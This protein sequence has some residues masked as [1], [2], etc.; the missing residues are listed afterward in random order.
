MGM[1]FADTETASEADLRSVGV[2]KYAEHPST[3][4]QLFSYTFDNDP[5][6]RLWSQEEGEE[7]PDELMD[8]FMDD[9]CILLFHNSQFDRVIIEKTLGIVLPIT[10]Y[11]CMMAQALSHS[12]PGALDKLGAAF[13]ISEDVRKIRDGHRLVLKFCKPRGKHQKW[14]TPETDPDDWARYKEYC[15][16]DTR[17]MR[18]LYKLLPRW[19]YPQQN[20]LALWILDQNMNDRG[21][22]IDLDLVQGAVRA[23]DKEQ[24]LLA[25]QTK[26]MTNGAVN[27]AS[28]RDAMLA[29]ILEEFGIILPDMRKAT[30]EKM[31]DD[32]EYPEALRDLIQVRLSTC[33]SS[34]AKYKKLIQ[35]TCR[36]GR[37]R[38]TVQYCGASRTGR[39]AGRIFQ[40]QNL[41][42]RGLLKEEDTKLG[43]ET[44]K[45]DGADLM[46]YDIMHLASSAIR[47]AIHAPQGKKLIISDLS[48]I[49]G[50]VL[51]YLAGEEWKVQAYRESDHDEKAPDLYKM[52]YAKA[53]MV[54]PMSVSKDQR[55]I[56][57]VLELACLG[58]DTLVLTEERDWKP[59]WNIQ[60]SDR[61]WDGKRWVRHQGL[62]RRGE[63]ETMDLLGVRVTPD[64][65]IKIRDGW[66]TADATRYAHIEEALEIGRLEDHPHIGL[67]TF[68]KCRGPRI[69]QVYDL[70]ECETNQFTILTEG[71][72]MIVHNC[73]YGGGVGAFVTFATSFGI[74]LDEL[75]EKVAPTLPVDVVEEAEGLYDWLVKM[76][77]TF[78]GLSR[79]TFVTIDCLKRLWRRGHP[80]TV[81]F[82]ADTE[83][84]IKDA[85]LQPGT[86][87]PFGNGIIA[88]KSGNWVR[89][90]LP[91]GH[92][93]CYPGMKIE[94][95][96]LEFKG[97]DQFTK[98]WGKINT[99][100]GKGVEN[101]TQAFSRD[102]FKFGQIA[103]EEAG[104]KVILVVHDELVTEVPDSD[105]FNVKT[106]E[107]IMSQQPPWALDL[108]LHAKGFED[109]RYH[110]ED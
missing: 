40:P 5:E 73:G 9:D 15:I 39:D 2:Y 59:L 88:Y 23:V 53:F 107:R 25:G 30:L 7:M 80:A 50:R 74:D 77:S 26:E 62:I 33:T 12:L 110:K 71:G 82:W 81:Q 48:A 60:T 58:E 52:A 35:A 21:M 16:M 32:P 78:H 20:E 44:L 99:W 66:A 106:L 19:N 61:V 17:S 94:D 89:L 87:F 24:S 79:S 69:E 100:G 104:Y 85:I 92:Q 49:E 29:H 51:A 65:P 42:S 64:H 63:K 72:P 11:R 3:R 101:L 8:A 4:I 37:L 98:K 96:K 55:Q 45:L 41:P 75:A 90:I 105:K 38:G 47:Y 70:L 83:N 91:S 102:I 76:K 56:G 54:D 31:L 13:N 46:G 43:I 10:R 86:K 22:L 6:I 108:P 18:E 14:A 109:Y 36:D 68:P 84:A 67:T 1:M 95:G 97:V 93:L 27:T 34:T 103:A 57:K 28:Q